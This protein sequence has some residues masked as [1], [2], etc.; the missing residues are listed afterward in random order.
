MAPEQSVIAS[1]ARSENHDAASAHEYGDIYQL[2]Q[3]IATT[4]APTYDTPTH[5]TSSNDGIAAHTYASLDDLEDSQSF[6][7]PP[8]LGPSPMVPAR[9]KASQVVQ[10]SIPIR[11]ALSSLMNRSVMA[12][13]RTL[14]HKLPN[15]IKE[16]DKAL[17]EADHM[18]GMT[19][20]GAAVGL[21]S[22]LIAAVKIITSTKADQSTGITT[23]INDVLKLHRDHRLDDDM[24]MVSPIIKLVIQALDWCPVVT[25]PRGT[26]VY[27]TVNEQGSS[28][29][30]GG[31]VVWD[32][33]IFGSTSSSAINR[34]KVVP[35]TI[36][37]ITPRSAFAIASITADPSKQ[38]AFVPGTTLAVELA[39][40]SNG[41]T[42]VKASQVN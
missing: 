6:Q 37:M 24:D 36:F 32:Q 7:P 14:S 34:S 9:L 16:A 33:F 35:R 2:A 28:I 42:T 40:T 11:I 30:K 20:D 29:A 15:I 10:N 3:P 4:A 18:L 13:A 31:T 21:N 5:A 38:V 22:E 27:V 12:C 23:H 1:E 8:V 26:F 39:V 19:V 25:C 41:V 17:S